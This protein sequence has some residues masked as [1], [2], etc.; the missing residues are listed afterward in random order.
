MMP[1]PDIVLVIPTFRRPQLLQALLYSLLDTLRDTPAVLVVAD[2]DCDETV[3]EIVENFRSLWPHCHYIAVP[4]RGLSH[5]RN[6]LVDCALAWVP[7]W[8]WLVMLDD[9]GVITPGW[10]S[11]LVSC[12]DSYQAQ[13]VGGPVEGILPPGAGFLARHSIFASR[14]RRKTG[15]VPSL[16][17]TQNLAVSRS[18]LKFVTLPLF[19]PDFNLSGGE[20][21]DLFRRASKAG[22]RLVW[23]DEALVF[24]PT[25]LARLSCGAVLSRYFTTGMYM[26]KIDVGYDGWQAAWV[27][28]LKGA[29]GSLKRL[30]F[31]AVLRNQADLAR[32]ILSSAHFA[33]RLS[34]LA[35]W[36]SARYAAPPTVRSLP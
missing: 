6:S 13:M 18:L 7:E 33:G 27:A 15:E 29:A 36:R 26:A 11:R 1:V 3:V 21:Y 24:E 5:V 9:D 25:P 4:A 35:G 14:S 23:C 34:G 2:N 16:N 28:G 19:S 22:A 20:D 30:V 10:L 31:A 12:G 32:A 17:S 8:R